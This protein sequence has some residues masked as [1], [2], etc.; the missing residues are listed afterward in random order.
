MF[1]IALKVYFCPFQSI[2]DTGTF[3]FNSLHKLRRTARSAH[4][5]TVYSFLHYDNGHCRA[6]TKMRWIR[7]AAPAGCLPQLLKARLWNCRN[8]P[9]RPCVGGWVV[10]AWLRAVSPP[11]PAP[12][13]V[14][15]PAPVWVGW[16]RGIRRWGGAPD[17]V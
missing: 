4:G 2:T 12:A 3:L 6:S 5:K 9:S 7:I 1:E 14:S 8:L 13:W 17:H 11:R 15:R 16:V 10:G